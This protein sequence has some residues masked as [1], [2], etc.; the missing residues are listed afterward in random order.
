MF[1]KPLPLLPRH[2][3]LIIIFLATIANVSVTRSHQFFLGRTI[4]W[5]PQLP[6]ISGNLRQINNA[7][8]HLVQIFSSF[9]T[10]IAASRINCPSHLLA[11]P[12][13]ALFNSSSNHQKITYSNP[14]APYLTM[15]N[16]A[17]TPNNDETIINA[18]RKRRKRGK[19]KLGKSVQ[20]RR[21]KTQNWGICVPIPWECGGC[22]SCCACHHCWRWH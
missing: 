6:Q 7:L 20:G 14:K 12:T 3:Q 10:D 17:G 4:P 21:Q 5:S 15:E 22:W 16:D 13:P 1:R 9:D 18:P 8:P 2:S 19:A 11:R